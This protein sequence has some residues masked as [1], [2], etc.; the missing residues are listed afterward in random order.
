MD[1]C[2]E[3]LCQFNISMSTLDSRYCVSVDGVL[4]YW[5]ITTE[6]SKEICVSPVHNI[7]K[8][9]LVPSSSWRQRMQIE[10]GQQEKKWVGL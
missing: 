1:D 10:V 2:D 7:R 5:G 6:K 8:G 9:K 4:D 3:I